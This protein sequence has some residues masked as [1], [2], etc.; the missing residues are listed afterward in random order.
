MSPK[1]LWRRIPW[2]LVGRF[3]R[4]PLK[5]SAMVVVQLQY[6]PVSDLRHRDSGPVGGTVS[7]TVQGS[8]LPRIRC[9]RIS[10]AKDQV[11]QGS[12]LPR[13]R[14][15]RIRFAKNLLTRAWTLQPSALMEIL[16][17]TLL[18][19]AF[20]MLFWIQKFYDELILDRLN[21]WCPFLRH[22]WMYLCTVN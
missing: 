9:A 19:L 11:C 15:A 16:T 20:R 2:M 12:G 17:C 10:F 18:I 5:D 1:R 22:V 4:L 7:G 8:G 14:Y 21:I 6:L 3:V 13:I